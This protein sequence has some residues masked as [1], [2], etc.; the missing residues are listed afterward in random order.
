[1]TGNY[2]FSSEQYLAATEIGVR[3]RGEGFRVIRPLEASVG[4]STEYSAVGGDVLSPGTDVKVTVASVSD[5]GTILDGAIEY[6]LLS[7]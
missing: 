3:R 7:I 1:M 4:N 6:E 5:N 2:V